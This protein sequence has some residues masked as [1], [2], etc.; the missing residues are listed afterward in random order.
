MSRRPS[1]RPTLTPHSQHTPPNSSSHDSSPLPDDEPLQLSTNTGIAVSQANDG[2]GRIF[3]YFQDSAGRLIERTYAN[4]WLQSPEGIAYN[5]SVIL[6]N[7]ELDTALAAVTYSDN[8]HIFRQIFFIDGKGMVQTTN[9]SSASDFSKGPWSDPL[10]IS[11]APAGSDPSTGLAACA[12]V[13]NIYGIRV[14]YG[15][16]DGG[17]RE[18]ALSFGDTSEWYATR[19]FMLGDAASGIGCTIHGTFEEGPWINLYMRTTDTEQL[20]KAY[21]DSTLDPG[22]DWLVDSIGRSVPRTAPVA[23]CNDGQFSEYLFYQ[24]SNDWLQGWEASPQSVG[25]TI[26][27]FLNI[28]EATNDTRLAS[29]YYG[30]GTLTLFRNATDASSIMAM[31][32]S[33]SGSNLFNM[34]IP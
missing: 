4:E 11:D 25:G 5:E 13:S 9:S 20:Q 6:E 23:V 19:D 16:S 7:A 31:A 32:R 12:D 2:S 17:I 21:W 29:A 30:N 3:I 18:L 34:T 24:A 10:T 28:A 14:Y 33:R 15:L 26:H 27:D 1:D 8:G 22:E